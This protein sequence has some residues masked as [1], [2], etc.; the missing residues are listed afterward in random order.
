MNKQ[1]EPYIKVAEFLGYVLGDNYEI[2]LYQ[3]DKKSDILFIINGH[4]SGRNIGD[5]LDELATRYIND[6]VHNYMNYH[7]NYMDKRTNNHSKIKS[8][9][10]FIKNENANLI[11]MLVINCNIGACVS[12]IEDI[13]RLNQL[14]T[15]IFQEQPPLLDNSKEINIL[16]E[17][18][19]SS[20]SELINNILR[21]NNLV[22]KEKLTITDKMIVIT[23]LYHLNIFQRKGTIPEVAE[24][25]NISEPSVYRYIS[26]IKHD[27]QQLRRSHIMR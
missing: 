1:L 3:I 2:V 8:S 26:R 5:P 12:I 24:C 23:D 17:S 25:L 11:G 10:F 16:K 13:L 4:I 18:A 6:E 27:T 20:T 15:S 7:V 9:T 22:K 19:I 14:T 21:N